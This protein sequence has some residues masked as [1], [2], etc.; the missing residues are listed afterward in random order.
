MSSFT[1]I[2]LV[3]EREDLELQ[4]DEV[5]VG[6]GTELDL[7]P[8]SVEWLQ[9]H[10]S[11]WLK[12][13][14]P[15]DPTPLSNYAWRMTREDA[16]SK[17]PGE[18]TIPIL[19]ERLVER[20]KWQLCAF[21]PQSTEAA[22][23]NTATARA[24]FALRGVIACGSRK[25]AL[26]LRN[27][28]AP[29]GDPPIQCHLEGSV[30]LPGDAAPTRVSAGV[31][32]CLDYLDV[33]EFEEQGPATFRQRHDYDGIPVII[34]AWSRFDSANRTWIMLREDVIAKFGSADFGVVS[35]MIE[36]DLQ[37]GRKT[38]VSDRGIFIL[39]NEV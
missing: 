1:Q 38:L 4:P 27:A 5:L 22:A 15:E 13:I 26:A 6:V 25:T 18:L 24:D 9:K 7:A 3:T 14:N 32:A 33:F 29:T 20:V 10:L 28:L 8:S 31:F 21:R 39:V 23:S 19:D 30:V 17:F 36:H 34:A 37:Q 2:E 16:N 11:Q 35:R 12:H